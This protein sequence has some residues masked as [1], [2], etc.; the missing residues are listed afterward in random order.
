MW[1]I[2]N[3]IIRRGVWNKNLSSAPK[4]KYGR[5]NVRGYEK[6]MGFTFVQLQHY[7]KIHDL[8][9]RRYE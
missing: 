7:V 3:T 8:G 9:V 4:D 2:E 6:L 1:T 5:I